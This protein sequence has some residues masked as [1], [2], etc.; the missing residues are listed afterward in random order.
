MTLRSIALAFLSFLT[1]YSGVGYGQ[2]SIFNVTVWN[3]DKT[4]VAL[5]FAQEAKSERI[6]SS[7]HELL[8]NPTVQHMWILRASGTSQHVVTYLPQTTER[9][10]VFV[11]IVVD[12]GI[13]IANVYCESRDENARIRMFEIDLLAGIVD[14]NEADMHARVREVRDQVKTQCDDPKLR[15]FTKQSHLGFQQITYDRISRIGF[16]DDY[17]FMEMLDTE[18]IPGIGVSEER[19]VQVLGKRWSIT[20]RPLEK[21][22]R[23]ADRLE[24][25]PEMQLFP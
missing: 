25:Y 21:K 2:E 9:L 11:P 3:N 8:L 10:Q 12:N 15:A 1:F 20:W 7:G 17:H 5:I 19:D 23:V 14:L 4:S 18:L 24:Q 6:P 16:T 22:L 13:L